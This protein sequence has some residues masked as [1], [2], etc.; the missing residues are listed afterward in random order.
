VDAGANDAT[1]FADRLQRQRDELADGCKDDHN[2][3]WLG[4]HLV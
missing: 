4:R 2:I 3:Q 1:A